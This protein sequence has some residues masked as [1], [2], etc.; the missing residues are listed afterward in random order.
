M[1]S[2][3]EFICIALIRHFHLNA[4]RIQRDLLFRE[5]RSIDKCLITISR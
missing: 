4:L 1:C 5:K 2:S 3:N